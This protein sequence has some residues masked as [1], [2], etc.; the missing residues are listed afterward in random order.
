MIKGMEEE[1]MTENEIITICHKYKFKLKSN[2]TFSKAGY[3]EFIF[4]VHISGNKQGSA[5]K[6]FMSKEYKCIDTIKYQQ[7]MMLV[8]GNKHIV[9]F[10]VKDNSLYVAH[11]ASS[12]IKD[13]KFKPFLDDFVPKLEKLLKTEGILI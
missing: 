6:E 3:P 5:F 7:K 9:D 4:S 1:K 2:I 12:V 11:F 10:L 8:S 13:K